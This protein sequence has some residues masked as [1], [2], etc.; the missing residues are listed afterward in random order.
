[1]QVARLHVS[2]RVPVPGCPIAP[3]RA[4]LF[5]IDHVYHAVSFVFDA[6]DSTLTWHCECGDYEATVMFASLAVYIGHAM[7]LVSRTCQRLSG[8]VAK[9]SFPLASCRL[10]SLSSILDI[11]HTLQLVFETAKGFS[12]LM[13]ESRQPLAILYFACIHS[14]RTRS[15]DFFRQNHAEPRNLRVSR[16]NRDW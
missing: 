6:S 15:Q 1:M 8:Y 4:A 7:R 13:S 12:L 5:R 11:L 9:I 2:H 3:H 16:N 14:L 10:A